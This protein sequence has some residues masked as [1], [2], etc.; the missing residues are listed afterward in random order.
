MKAIVVIGGFREAAER[1][2]G[3]RKI[4]REAFT[5]HAAS[6]TMVVYREWNQ[7]LHS[8]GKMLASLGVTECAVAAYSWGCGHGLK[9]FAKGFS[10]R[11]YASLCD[12][13]YFSYTLLGRFLAMFD[14]TV[15]FPAHVEVVVWVN[16]EMDHPGGDPIKAKVMPRKP[17][18]LPYPHTQIDDS[19]EYKH[20]TLQMFR[21]Y[22]KTINHQN[23]V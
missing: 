20:D 1:P 4:F 7:D 3:M 6:D 5:R 17:R 10:G 14:K 15:K 18:T 12:P 9:E 2:T 23:L 11:I 19:P 22:V 13:V 16:Q 21:L 8:L